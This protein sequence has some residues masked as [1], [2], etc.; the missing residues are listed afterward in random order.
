MKVDDDLFFLRR[1]CTFLEIRPEMVGPAKSATFAAPEQPRILVHG[2]PIPF[3]VLLHVLYKDRVFRWGPRPLPD[4]T[5]D[6]ALV[7]R[8]G[9]AVVACFIVGAVVVGDCSRHNSNRMRGRGLQ[10]K[11]VCMRMFVFFVYGNE[12]QLLLLLM[13]VL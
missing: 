12:T 7:L 3:T 11:V 9:I 13:L 4:A 1:E 5:F 2:V 10:E 8:C 6:L